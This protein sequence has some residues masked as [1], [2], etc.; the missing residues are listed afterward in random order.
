MASDLG[1]TLN[2]LRRICSRREYCSRDI[3]EKAL[4]RLESK[5]A[6]S[7]ALAVLTG[8]NFVSDERY[9]VAFAG[10]RSSIAGWGELKIRRALA[11]K[12]IPSDI[13]DNA[14]E[15]IDVS[16]KDE[17]LRRV[18]EVKYKMLE[19]DACV[20]LKMLKFAFSRGYTYDEVNEV[21]SEIMYGKNEDL[22]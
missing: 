1:D 12:G 11:L 19:G 6:A 22:Q 2:Y 18:L 13:I 8:E 3:Y 4:K 16:R 15:S 5:D 9:A 10:D 17:K 14:L 7:E 20:R 21:V